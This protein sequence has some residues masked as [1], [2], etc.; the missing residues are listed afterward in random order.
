LLLHKTSWWTHSKAFPQLQKVPPTT[1]W[2]FQAFNISLRNWKEDFSVDGLV[3]NPNCSLTNILLA[4][5]WCRN[6]PYTIF[7][8]TFGNEV[9][10]DI[11][12]QLSILFLSPFFKQWFYNGIF[13]WKGKI[14]SYKDL[15]KMW[16]KGKLIKG[17]FNFR[18]FIEISLYTLEFFNFKELVILS[19]S[20]VY[21]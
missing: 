7:S 6:L 20:S 21:E 9:S 14:P 12:L 17:V 4:F 10:T 5:I 3:Q 15:L 18:I 1:S 13:K 19:I 2:L 16:F 11:G 8:G